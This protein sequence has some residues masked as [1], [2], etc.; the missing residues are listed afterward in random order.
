[1]RCL[2]DILAEDAFLARRALEI[3][4][5]EHPS[6]LRFDYGYLHP[7]LDHSLPPPAR[8]TQSKIVLQRSP[9]RSLPGTDSSRASM[10][11]RR[12][13]SRWC[14]PTS[15]SRSQTPRCW[16][17]FPEATDCSSPSM[18]TLCLSRSS[19]SRPTVCSSSS[20]APQPPRPLSSGSSTLVIG[21]WH[22]DR[23]AWWNS[24]C[25][26]TSRSSIA[27]PPPVS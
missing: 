17:T 25:F 5:L 16:R 2:L 10:T 18:R 24:H 23:A 1:A 11:H 15:P 14:I 8:L 21:K 19:S 13:D 9:L 6:D 7:D 26:L 20:M 27:T 12:R 3:Y 4:Q 22:R